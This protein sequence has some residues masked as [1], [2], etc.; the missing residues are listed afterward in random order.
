MGP[1]FPGVELSFLTV[2]PSG[3]QTYNTKQTNDQSYHQATGAYSSDITHNK[4]KK[5]QKHSCIKHYKTKIANKAD[6]IH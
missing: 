1:D 6:E 3:S 4:G 5:K 2:T